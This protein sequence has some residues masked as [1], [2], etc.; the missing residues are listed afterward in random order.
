MVPRTALVSVSVDATL[1]QV[2]RIF[3]E[4]LYSRLPVYEGK[5]ENIIGVLHLKDLI[6]VWDERR[7]ALEHRRPARPFR[8]RR[9][10][11]KLL[12]VP[13]TKPLAGLVDEFR[14]NHVQMAMVVDEFGSITGLVTLEDVLEQIFGEFEDEHD[15]KRARPLEPGHEVIEVEGTIPIRDLQ[16]HWGIELPTDAGF[17]TLAGFLMFQLGEI[18]AEGESVEFDGRCYTIL[19]MRRNRIQR[20]EIRKIA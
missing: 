18:P 14:T 13:E 11:G 6:R 17:E 4:H 19:E 10:L 20:V 5:P 8:L 12:V 2:L 9:I 3:L 7:Q 1:D 16:S 15:E